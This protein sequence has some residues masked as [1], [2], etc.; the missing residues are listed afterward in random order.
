MRDLCGGVTEAA[1]GGACTAPYNDSSWMVFFRSLRRL[2]RSSIRSIGGIGI[3]L[4]KF[5][6]RSVAWLSILRRALACPRGMSG[7][8]SLPRWVLSMRRGRGFGLPPHGVTWPPMIAPASS[9]PAIGS[10]LASLASIA[11]NQHQPPAANPLPEPT[12]SPTAE[13]EA[14]AD[15]RSRLPK[16]TAEADS[17]SRSRS[18]SRGRGRS[19]SRISFRSAP[20]GAVS[21]WNGSG[22]DG[23]AS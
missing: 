12:P 2:V 19:R 15:S 14:A 20:R 18:R 21:V 22:S 13:A 6:A 3:L 1:L 7:F 5:A 4:L 17:R 23:R 10:A 11:A 8:V 16:P 9:R